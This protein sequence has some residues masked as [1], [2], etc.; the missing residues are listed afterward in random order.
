M[1]NNGLERTRR[2]GVPRLRGAVVRVSPRRS[3]R[4]YLG[5][6]GI[7]P[8]AQWLRSVESAILL[9]AMLLL[10]GVESNAAES[11]SGMF[12]RAVDA[13]TH[14]LLTLGD[15][16]TY[17]MS[18]MWEGP[19]PRIRGRFKRQ[20]AVL[21]LNDSS[22]RVPAQLQVVDR[23]PGNAA[24]GRIEAHGFLDHLFTIGHPG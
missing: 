6:S 21:T 19:M 2:V 4:C 5:K 13:Y 9:T 12:V 3:T 15:D 16:G 23:L 11:R 7:R 8:V 17:E 24:S 20:G 10:L 14:N 1:H 18:T 22:G